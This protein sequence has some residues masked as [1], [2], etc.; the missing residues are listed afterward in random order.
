MSTP[1]SALTSSVVGVAAVTV[2][3]ATKQA[4]EANAAEDSAARARA[5]ALE[6]QSFAAD[7]YASAAR[8]RASAEAAMKEAQEAAAA[9]REATETAAKLQR[10]EEQRDRQQNPP[11]GTADNDIRSAEYENSTLV[12]VFAIECYLADYRLAAR[13]LLWAG[14]PDGVMEGIGK[15]GHA[16][17][18]P[19]DGLLQC[20]GS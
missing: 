14:K 3:E 4:R 5:S 11:P 18:R 16:S 2:N 1:L 10:E 20:A 19:Q 17:R 13:R 9:A 12:V 15:R 7:A 8:A 6:A